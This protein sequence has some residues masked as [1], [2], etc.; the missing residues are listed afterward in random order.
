MVSAS[1]N[2]HTRSIFPRS[3]TIPPSG[4]GKTY[5]TLC[6]DVLSASKHQGSPSFTFLSKKKT[7]RTASQSVSGL[8]SVQ[9]PAIPTTF[10]GA[11]IGFPSPVPA[12]PYSGT[13]L[14][15]LHVQNGKEPHGRRHDINATSCFWQTQENT[16]YFPRKKAFSSLFC[17]PQLLSSIPRP[18][19]PFLP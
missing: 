7:Y 17:V 11:T 10:L 1:G 18:T 15:G 16:C 9:L 2:S 5:S 8:T 12:I 6:K 13:P 4:P 3:R 19:R 14:L